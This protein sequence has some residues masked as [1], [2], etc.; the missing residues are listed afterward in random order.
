MLISYMKEA[1]KIVSQIKLDTIKEKDVAD[2]PTI[3]HLWFDILLN[4][5][6]KVIFS[7]LD[8]F[9]D[10]EDHKK[11]IYYLWHRINEQYDLETENEGKKPPFK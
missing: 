10:R 2:D 9:V 4:K 8:S 3:L 7:D 6:N 5:D 1:K 11:Q